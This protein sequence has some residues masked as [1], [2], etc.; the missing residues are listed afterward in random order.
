M[1][2]SFIFV[3]LP[4]KHKAHTN[5]ALIANLIHIDSVAYLSVFRVR[6]R[7]TSD[8]MGIHAE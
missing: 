6:D 3:L 2:V 5:N 1:Q 7:G 8:K 4:R